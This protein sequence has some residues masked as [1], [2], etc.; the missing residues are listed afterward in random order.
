MAVYFFNEDIDLP[1]VN[2]KRV[3]KWLQ[4]IVKNH[5]KTL[6]D[7]NY[8]FTSD[9]YILQINQEHLNHDYYT[10]VITF[11]YTEN[12]KISGDIYIS[13]DTVKS[14]A[15]L[16]KQEFN[17]EF[18]RVIIHGILH[19]I[20]FKDKTEPDAKEMRKQE[21]TSLEILKSISE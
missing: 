20:G 5:T 13:L 4:L 15:E 7:I 10:D 19:L 17:K 3:K 18:H 14:N 21:E 12:N 9:S 11:D 2:K 1:Q 6:G 16:L 8:I